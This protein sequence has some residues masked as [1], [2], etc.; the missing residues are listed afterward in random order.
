MNALPH[1]L[2]LYVNPSISIF[3]AI[4]FSIYSTSNTPSL[5]QQE[6]LFQSILSKMNFAELQSSE[7]FEE[8]GETNN[9]GITI[10]TPQKWKAITWCI[11]YIG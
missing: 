9:S 2:Q 3:I 5:V 7:V 4:T 8:N 11:K 6:I 10:H 1:P